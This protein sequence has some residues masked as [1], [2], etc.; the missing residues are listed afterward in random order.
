MHWE[1]NMKKILVSGVLSFLAVISFA[2]CGD[3]DELTQEDE[4][5]TQ[6]AV[7]NLHYHV[8]VIAMENHDA[9]QIYGNTTDAPY[10][11]SL[12]T[13]YASA[14]NFVDTLPSLWSEPHYVL[15]EG[16]KNTFTD[17]SFVT[18]D[19]PSASNSTSNTQHLV[20]QMKN[21]QVSWKSYQE[22]MTMGTCPIHSA[23]DYAPKH[24]PFVFFKD[25]S[26]SPPSASNQYCIDHH[27][28]YSSLKN[29]LLATPTKMANYV[30][31]TPNLCH[32]MH[33]DCS[34]NQVGAIRSG[35]NWLAAAVPPIIN[36]INAHKGV[37]FIVWDEGESDPKIPFVV[38]GP[39]VKPGNSA[40]QYSHASLVKSIDRIFGLPVLGAAVNSNDLRA[41]FTDDPLG[42]ANLGDECS[43]DAKKTQ[44]GI[45]GCGKTDRYDVAGFNDAH[46]YS[47]SAW[48]GYDCTKAAE[49]EGYTAAEETKLLANCSLSCGVCL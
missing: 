5:T 36:Y 42:V 24:D 14:S 37:L 2:A 23:G 29:D 12:R 26:G 21:H 33:D 40:V 38:I 32:D 15:M 41:F 49:Q 20:T 48:I 34:A 44:P 7:K 35:D 17:H 1:K 10:I 22:G 4:G 9:G 47:C 28:P 30:F 27:S 39:K 3:V 43:S 19:D 8:F 18:D 46:G 6:E 25:V 45:C 11:N 31:I 16:G 13:K